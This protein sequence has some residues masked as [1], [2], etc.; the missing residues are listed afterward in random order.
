M[1]DR[2]TQFLAFHS[3]LPYVSK[4]CTCPRLFTRDGM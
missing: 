2:P 3:V 4:P 1:R